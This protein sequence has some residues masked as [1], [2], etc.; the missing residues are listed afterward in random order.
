MFRAPLV[1]ELW[2]I[3]LL[4]QETQVWPLVREDPIY[5]GAA[6][7]LCHN[8]WA[9]AL[10]P[11]NRNCW[12]HVLQLLKPMC[13]EP[14]LRNEKPPQWE[15]CTLQLDSSPCSETRESPHSSEDLEQSKINKKKSW[16]A[17]S[18]CFLRSKWGSYTQSYAN[19]GSSEKE[20]PK[21]RF[22]KDE[23]NWSF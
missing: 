22:P 14:A 20:M 6:K 16:S 17:S 18:G 1:V 7:P 13:L 12:A 15:V 5:C 21:F 8:C 9:S 11:R 4:T 23:R 2:R 10:G 19:K 3:C